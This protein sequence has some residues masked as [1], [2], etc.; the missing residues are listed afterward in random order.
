MSRLKKPYEISVW[1]DVW[2]GTKF[3]EVRKMV[4]G[5]NTMESRQRAFEPN[6][7]RN[8]NG[9]NELTFKLYK[10]YRD[11]VT[12][13]RVNNPFVDEIVNETKLKL[14]YKNKWYDFIVKNIH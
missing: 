7:K 13:E 6:L 10:K 1:E 12:G 3:V 2:N 11:D 9:S 5:S 14:N 4:I 8:V